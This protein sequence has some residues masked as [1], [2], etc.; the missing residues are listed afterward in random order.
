METQTPK[1]F[2]K[3]PLASSLLKDSSYTLHSLGNPNPSP[4]PDPN[5]IFKGTVPVPWKE[6]QEVA[7][8]PFFRITNH[9]GTAVLHTVFLA[10]TRKAT[11]TQDPEADAKTEGHLLLHVGRGITGQ[12]GIA[13]GGFLATVI[14]EVCGNLIAAAN[15]DEGLRM[16]TARLSLEYKR[17]VFIPEDRGG[18][19]IVAS[20]RVKR[21]EGRKVFIEGVVRNGAGVVCTT[22]EA[23][24]VRKRALPAAL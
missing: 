5:S 2:L 17:P 20:A 10:R 4:N 6:K 21:L 3:N 22:A 24:F 19:V 9:S 16:F 8:N 11:R 18:T 12:T 13:H 1:P 14:D 23:I 7:V 15:L